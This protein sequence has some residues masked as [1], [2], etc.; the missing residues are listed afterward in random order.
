MEENKLIIEPLKNKYKIKIKNKKYFK[1]PGKE[2]KNLKKK[3]E[4][5]NY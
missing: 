5:K 1:F 3:K 4:M 2:K